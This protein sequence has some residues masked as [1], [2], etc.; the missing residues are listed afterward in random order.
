MSAFASGFLTSAN[1]PQPKADR[2]PLRILLVDDDEDYYVL[3][4]AL[5]SDV[6]DQAYELD[7]KVSYDEALA[8]LQHAA[9]DVCLI[10]YQLGGH[11]GLEILN[12]VRESGDR[13]PLI[14]LTGHGDRRVDQAALAAGAA[15]YLFKAKTDAAL[16]ER[17][18]R[19]A[20]EHARSLEALRQNEIRLA[21]L[22]EQEQTRARELEHAY[23][24][25]H[26]AEMLRDD[27]TDMIIHDLR[28]PLTVITINLDL[29]GQALSRL[30]NSESLPSLTNA[31]TAARRVAWM[32]D[33]LLNVSKLEAGRLQLNFTPLAV[34]DWLAEK[35]EMYRTQL[36]AKQITLALQTPAKLPLAWVDI[37]LID[38][39][40]DNLIG[41]AIKYTHLG[42]HIAITAEANAE[43]LTLC[44]QDDGEGIRPD[45][46]ER[47]F[48]KFARGTSSEVTATR[49]GAGL[50]LAFCRLAV[51]AHGGTITA[52]GAPGRGT[53]F[54]V[55]LPLKR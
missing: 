18:I 54:T 6:E 3:T 55:T 52:D 16:L 47:I 2:A 53:T 49:P 7:W 50:G 30:P 20:I 31:R 25:L 23:A 26:H 15:D 11:N 34:A 32:I 45:E 41:N 35:Q 9:Y 13:T 44:V 51:A 43:R 10:D 40:L 42:G 24:E 19:Y 48:E 36:E 14:M 5:L 22:Y 27:L 38:R 46:R 28:G 29:I 37:E 4:R 21:A 33:D 17:S 1:Q 12:A 8:A 39:V